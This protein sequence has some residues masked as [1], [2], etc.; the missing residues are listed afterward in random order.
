MHMASVL[1]Q[2]SPNVSRWLVTQ[3][4]KQTRLEEG[5]A[6]VRMRIMG[7]SYGLC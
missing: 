7:R 1:C 6:G 5:W 3:V 2:G 4:S